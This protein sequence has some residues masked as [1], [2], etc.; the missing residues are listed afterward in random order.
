MYLFEQFTEC[1]M[2][3]NSEDFV[4][5]TRRLLVSL[6][7]SSLILLRVLFGFL[8]HLCEFADE[9]MMQPPTLAICFGPTLL[10]IPEGKDQVFYHNYVNGFV[11]GLIVHHEKVFPGEHELP[12]PVYDKYA[13]D[14]H[15]MDYVD[16]VE[17]DDGLISGDD[18]VLLGGVDEQDTELQRD[19]ENGND[20]NNRGSVFSR[21]SVPT[22]SCSEDT[23]V[24]DLG[25]RDVCQQ[26]KLTL[27]E[28]FLHR[29]G[30][31]TEPSLPPSS[32]SSV[33]SAL[34]IKYN[35]PALSP[36]NNNNMGPIGGILTR[37]P[38]VASLRD[39]LTH[40]NPS[41]VG[42]SHSANKVFPTEFDKV[43]RTSIRLQKLSTFDELKSPIESPSERPGASNNQSPA[44]SYG[45]E[46]EQPSSA[47]SSGSPLDSHPSNQNTP[48]RGHLDDPTFE[49]D[50]AIQCLRT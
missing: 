35:E 32:R 34:E 8:S 27:K 38:V 21:Q 39:Q 40:A 44:D 9:N 24:R 29:G 23:S 31:P 3:E 7:T 28:D 45:K 16:D 10:P 22:P 1:S 15:N 47:S 6:P 49:L 18:E 13:F 33:R 26:L 19:K 4:S 12:G 36:R 2:A 11:R 5:K 50:R 48:R 17:G 46:I 30:T 20:F 37:P 42:S 25:F 14:L 43:S 41:A